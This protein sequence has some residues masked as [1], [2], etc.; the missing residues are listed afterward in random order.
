MI[1]ILLIGIVLSLASVGCMST[2][3]GL[4][5]HV[6][7]HGCNSQGV[8]PWSDGEP[9]NWYDAGTREIVLAPGQSLKKLAHEACHAHQHQTIIDAVGEASVSPAS[10]FYDLREWLDTSEGIMY[11]KVVVGLEPLDPHGIVLL[12][13]FAE[14]C[15]R[16]LTDQLTEPVRKSYFEGRGFK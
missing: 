15:G 8:C 10:G 13:D 5:L 6:D 1:R 7:E 4:H 11:A 16:F 9:R 14:A 12:E 3:A 2:P